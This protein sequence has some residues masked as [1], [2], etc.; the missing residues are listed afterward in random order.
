MVSKASS[1]IGVFVGVMSLNPKNIN[2]FSTDFY[3]LK[4]MYLTY[5]YSPFGKETFICLQLTTYSFTHQSSFFFHL[6]L[7]TIG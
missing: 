3:I 7:R 4:N 6:D 5:G 1:T 2:K